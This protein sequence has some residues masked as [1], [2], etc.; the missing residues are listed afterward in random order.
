MDH[1]LYNVPL[2]GDENQWD[3]WGGGGSSGREGSKR[4]CLAPGTGNWLGEEGLIGEFGHVLRVVRNA[5]RVDMIARLTPS[6][7]CSATS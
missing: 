3:R 4:D 5:L 7:W 6:S 1:E 2:P